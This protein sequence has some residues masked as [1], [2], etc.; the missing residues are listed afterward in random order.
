MMARTQ[1][2]VTTTVVGD[3]SMPT[4]VKIALYRITQEAL[5]NVVKHAKAS[6]ARVNLEAGGEKITLR[7]SDNG[8][9]FDLEVM[10][11]HGM[12]VGFMRE[13]AG[14]IDAQLFINSQPD[15]GTEVL[16]VWEAQLWRRNH[17]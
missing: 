6:Q 15:Q 14:D 13:R 7:I 12:G 17:E 2:V 10:E 5:N 11:L 1:T 3:P 16:I 8:R 4:E 9:G